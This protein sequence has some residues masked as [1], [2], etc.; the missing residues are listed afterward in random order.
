MEYSSLFPARS[1]FTIKLPSQ[2]PLASQGP[3]PPQATPTTRHTPVRRRILISLHVQPPNLPLTQ[4]VPSCIPAS[5]CRMSSCLF[6]CLSLWAFNVIVSASFPV[7]SP[8]PIPALPFMPEPLLPV[9][10]APRAKLTAV[11]GQKGMLCTRTTPR[12]LLVLVGLFFTDKALGRGMVW[13]GGSPQGPHGVGG[14][15]QFVFCKH[16]LIGK[17]SIHPLYVCHLQPSHLRV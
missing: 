15:K 2:R 12:V 7:A 4:I 14:N 17:Q 3:L 10:F 8:L 16:R 9:R 1:L 6:H 13:G 11:A 5:G